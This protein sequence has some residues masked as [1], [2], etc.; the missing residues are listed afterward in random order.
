MRQ[1]LPGRGPAFAVLLSAALLALAGSCGGG[2]G[3]KETPTTSPVT[4]EVTIVVRTPTQAPDIRHVD[5]ARQQKLRLFLDQ[6]GGVVDPNA[7]MYADLTQ[8]GKEEAVV[9]LNSGGEGGD[10]AVFV[11]SV[12]GGN[13]ELLLRTYAQDTSLVA[14]VEGG[15]LTVTEPV[16]AEGD[17]LCCPSGLRVTTYRWDGSKLA[18]AGQEE[19]KPAQ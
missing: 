19:T 17:P 6:A 2:S 10:I 4:T 16:Y 3:G 13:V 5:L 14:A 7:V 12:R 11:Y 18:V 8:D 1:G 9:P 15:A